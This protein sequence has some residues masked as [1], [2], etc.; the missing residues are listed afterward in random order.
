MEEKQ[1]IARWQHLSQLKASAFLFEFFL[2]GVK[3]YS[4]LYLRLVTQCD[5]APLNVEGEAGGYER[6]NRVRRQ[7][8]ILATFNR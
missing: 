5:R 1:Q 3:K 7:M 6:E 2:L 4:N 8:Q